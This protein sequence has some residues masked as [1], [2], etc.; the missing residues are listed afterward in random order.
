MEIATCYNS[1][2][3]KITRQRSF[4]FIF[5]GENKALQHVVKDIP[6]SDILDKT[7]NPRDYQ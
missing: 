3:R 1:E 6:T 2:Q 7:K 4:P 5:K